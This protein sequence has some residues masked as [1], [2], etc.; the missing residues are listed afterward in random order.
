MSIVPDAARPPFGSGHIIPPGLSRQPSL[1]SLQRWTLRAGLFLLPLAYLPSTYDRW[2]LPKLLL[3]RALVIALAAIL[4]IRVLR[5]GKVVVKRTPLDLPW[6]A[7]LASAAL[8]T[9]FAINVN[10]AVFGTYSRYDGLLTL[11]VY[12]ALFW[13]AVQ[14]LEGSHDVRSLLRV[15]LASA[16]VVAGIAIA[17]S[18]VQ[19]LAPVGPELQGTDALQG[20]IVRAYGSLGQWEVLGE[21]LVL[22][23]PLAL[24]ECGVATSRVA[25]MLA[26]NAA[27][28]IG[29][30]VVLTFSRSTWAALLL[31]TAVLFVGVR[32]WSDRRFLAAGVGAL[33]GIAILVAVISAT[34]GSGFLSAIEHRASTVLHPG[35][36][37]VRPLIWRDGLK[38]VASRP[39][40]GYGPDTF[41][42][43]FPRF[44]TVDY[45]VPV[46]KAHAE[47][48]QVAAT[49]GIA[50]V[51]A[52]AWLLVVFAM[53]FW[54][55]RTQPQAY[56]LLAGA[57]GYEAMLQVNFT[58]IG[59]AFPFWIY[60][61][62]A[63]H[64]WNAVRS[65]RE[66][67]LAPP[68]AT[69]LRMA[70][71]ALPVLALAGV[72][73]P[74][75]ADSALRQAVVAD[76]LGNPTEAA[77]AA[78]TA[79]LLS[80]RESVN[81]VEAGNIAFEHA[82]WKA[83]RQAYTLASQLGTYNSLVY[84]NL[85]IADRELGLMPEALAAARAAYEIDRF[86]PLNQ[87]LLAQ[88]GQTRNPIPP[89]NDSRA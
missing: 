1:A 13:L 3:A 74:Y 59:S 23:W 79:R 43:S 53:A 55:G 75:L 71:A 36:W 18:I 33:A 72:L 35:Q 86:N 83:A 46:D 67:K 48:L 10:V 37:D 27:V 54:R 84:R 81:A 14:T 56:A 2:V 58:A 88:F 66:V 52:Y 70:I 61:A 26:L 19:S 29:V 7:F 57:V 76:Q 24:W 51:A 77:S 47:L 8:S 87:A 39:I 49:Q 34:G 30:A 65:R 17:Q 9:L 78:N 42:L 11:L 82:D 12:A 80:P 21:F 50:G 15:L 44:N 32:P 69:G 73:L 85:A 22:A 5:E 38:V 45:H 41:G 60:A 16:Y 62:A 40:L 4:A 25:R 28:V 89:P 68:A 63:M 64:S 6:L 20:S 31:A